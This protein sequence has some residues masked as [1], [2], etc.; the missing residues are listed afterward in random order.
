MYAVFQID[1]F[2]YRAEEGATIRVPL[3]SAKAGEKVELGDILLVKK[4]DSAIIGTPFVSGAKIQAE[5]VGLTRGEKLMTF[6]YKRRTKSR[7]THGHKQDYTE[8]KVTK[9]V[10]PNA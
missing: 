5:V 6:K 8:I 2:Q 10:S 3:Q 1:G 9:I 4:D 7:R